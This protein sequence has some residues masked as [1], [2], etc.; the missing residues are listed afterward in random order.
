MEGK[1]G[2]ER[3]REEGRGEGRR[4]KREGEKSVGTRLTSLTRHIHTKYSKQS[5]PT[6]N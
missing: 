3:G 2:R 5:M 6:A 4:E 1:G